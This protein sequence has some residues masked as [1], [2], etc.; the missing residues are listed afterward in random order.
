MTSTQNVLVVLKW[1]VSV[2]NPQLPSVS[3]VS[4][5]YMFPDLSFLSDW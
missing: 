3:T 1:V 5:S 2:S 4:L